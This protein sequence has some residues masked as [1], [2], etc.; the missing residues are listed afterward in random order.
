MQKQEQSQSIYSKRTKLFPT[1]GNKI[2]NIIVDQGKVKFLPTPENW[3]RF[4]SE[5][6][7]EV[8]VRCIELDGETFIYGEKIKGDVPP[9]HPNC[10][11]TL[12]LY[13]D[14]MRKKNQRE[15]PRNKRI[16]A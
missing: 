16:S 6:T 4:T 3:Y 1:I 2:Q 13:N 8:Y 5:R 12:T 14:E 11:C 9:V 10:K 7:K 15:S